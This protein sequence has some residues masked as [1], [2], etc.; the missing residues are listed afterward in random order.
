MAQLAPPPKPHRIAVD[1]GG[2]LDRVRFRL[3]QILMTA[4]TVAMT[5]WFCTLGIVPAIIALLT[6]KHV[7]VAILAAG[8]HLS[9]P[10]PRES[11]VYS[12][13]RDAGEGP[14]WKS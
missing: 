7:L 9:P 6:A 11:Q 2:S 5:G 13:S 3:W 14:S 4:V 12:G 10:L 1:D 8:L